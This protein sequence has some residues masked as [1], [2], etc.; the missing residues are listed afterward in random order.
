MSSRSP[1]VAPA[2]AAAGAFDKLDP[3]QQQ[4]KLMAKPRPRLNEVT[5]PENVRFRTMELRDAAAVFHLGE[6]VFNVD[7]FPQLYRTWDSFEVLE[8]V[9]ELCII[10]E[11]ILELVPSAEGSKAATT[12]DAITK[13]DSSSSSRNHHQNSRIVG[14]IFG[15][16]TE[17]RKKESSC[18]LLGWIGVA[19]SHQR[20]NIGTVLAYKLFN[21]FMEEDIN[22]IIA[23]TP[24]E[25]TPAIGFLHRMGFA[26]PVYHVYM[27]LNLAKKAAQQQQQQSA[28][29]LPPEAKAIKIRPMTID[30]LV[31]VH[32]LG[33]R[34][35]DPH[36]YPN[37][38]RIWS[39]S[40][41]GTRLQRG[42]LTQSFG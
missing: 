19:P 3:Q 7:S 37:L 12:G 6:E 17:K 11:E 13:T 42:A 25:N 29:T 35:Y 16:I 24:M 23:D 15:S 31:A 36:L 22:L 10:A 4:V 8:M 41:V 14:F 32:D 28:V 20:R 9:G 40:E 34:I 2:A 39:E 21:L 1:R 27:S 38:Y 30:D 26:T 33:E 5:V 18:G